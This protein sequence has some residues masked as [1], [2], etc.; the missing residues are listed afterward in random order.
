MYVIAIFTSKANSII[1]LN[2]TQNFKDKNLVTRF[3]MDSTG[4]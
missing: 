2:L 4:F 3:G 1:L